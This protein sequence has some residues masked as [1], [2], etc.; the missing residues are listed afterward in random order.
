M[1]PEQAQPAAA[2]PAPNAADIVCARLH[3]AAQPMVFNLKLPIQIMTKADVSR[4]DR[5]MREFEDFFASAAVSGASAKTVP[6]PS[7]LLTILLNEN[8]FNLLK[9]DDRQKV[10]TFL[11]TLRAKVPVIHISFAV[12]PKPDFLMRIVN[13]FRTQAHPYALVQIGLRPSIAAGCV[14]RTTNKYF[15]FS[16]KKHFEDNKAKLTEALKAVS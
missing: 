13:W 8:N 5:E 3:A 10:I 11:G 14:I 6:Q 12:D 16:F 2:A 15:D 1:A 4:L 9:A 7:Q